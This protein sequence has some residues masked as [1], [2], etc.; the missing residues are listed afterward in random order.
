MSIEMNG[1]NE[2][3]LEWGGLHTYIGLDGDGDRLHGACIVLEAMGLI[4]RAIDEEH[5]VFWVPIEANKEARD[6]S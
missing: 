3:I 5:H 6:D 1:L 4:K 2:R